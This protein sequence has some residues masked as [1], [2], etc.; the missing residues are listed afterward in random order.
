MIAS[1]LNVRLNKHELD[2]G[3]SR[4]RR[5]GEQIQRELAQLIQNGV[6]DP[7]VEWVTISAVKVTK[8]FS[9]ATVYFTVIGNYEE[10]VDA[11]I[12]EGL[13]RATGFLRRELG[14]RIKL[15]ITPELHF[16]YDISTIR[17]DR[18]ASLIVAAVESDKK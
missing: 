17:G 2:D 14:R 3:N 1:R 5:V 13:S 11:D 15:R 8:D 7:R 9:H 6:K 18:L 10:T 16:K 12:L 4:V